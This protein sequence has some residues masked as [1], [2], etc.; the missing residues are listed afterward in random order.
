MCIVTAVMITP[1]L[2]LA[3]LT[4]GRR[5]A[6][7]PGLARELRAHADLSQPDMAAVV[8]VDASTISRWEAG[9]RRPSGASGRRY[10][11]L[12]AELAVDEPEDDLEGD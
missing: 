3:R 5:I 8:G 7:T 4:L 10:L 9:S 1:E 6:A 2:D 12:L 11:M